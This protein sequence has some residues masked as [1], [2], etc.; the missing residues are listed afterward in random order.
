MAS[1]GGPFLIFKEFIP[2]TSIVSATFFECVHD[3]FHQKATALYLLTLTASSINIFKVDES[4]SNAKLFLCA[5]FRLYG[6]PQDVR[7]IN[8]LS[9]DMTLAESQQIVV[10]LD[11][12]KLVILSF[13]PYK[14]CLNEHRL[15]N[16]E[17]SAFGFGSEVVA[18]SHGQLVSHAQGME[19]YLSVDDMGS[20][21]C[22]LIY[23]SQFLFVPLGSGEATNGWAD[24]TQFV[25]DLHHRLGLL[26]KVL[27]FCFIAGYSQP[28]IAVLQ[29]AA[30]LPIGHAAHVLHTCTVTALAV[31]VASKSAS[32]LWQRSNL[33]HDSIRLLKLSHPAL[34]GCVAVIAV[35]ALLVVGQDVATGIAT[36]G[37]ASTTVHSSIKLSP[38]PHHKGLE[39]D[40]SRWIETRPQDH[41]QALVG[42]AKDGKMVAVHLT[43]IST[44]ECSGTAQLSSLQIEFEADLLAMSVRPSSFC[45][46]SCGRFWFIGS[47]VADGLLL[48][49]TETQTPVT[50]NPKAH[51][52]NLVGFNALKGDAG[53]SGDMASASP[54]PVAST[55]A[56][57]GA[58]SAKRPRRAP[59]IPVD[60]S[61]DMVDEEVAL[62]S[63]PMFKRW[64]VT[65]NAGSI[66]CTFY[67]YKFELEVADTVFVVGPVLSGSFTSADDSLEH[68]RALDW[69]DVAPAKE[70]NV[71]S[72]SAF[73]EPRKSKEAL[74]LCTSL[75]QH[76]AISR[77]SNGLRMA[78][79]T[80]S[81]MLAA[82]SL[83]AIQSPSRAFTLLFVGFTLKS[84]LFLCA[85]AKSIHSVGR[86]LAAAAVV[87]VSMREI[88]PADAGF[89]QSDCTLAGGVLSAGGGVV[90]QVCTQTIRVT[91][92]SDPHVLDS[93]ALQ[94]LLV[95]DS[96]DVGG[97]GGVDGEIIVSAS[98]M[99]GLVA[100][101]TSHR[102]L[103]VLQYDEEEECLLCVHSRYNNRCGDEIGSPLAGGTS[104]SM[105][106]SLQLDIV[107]GSAADSSTPSL[108]A[109][110]TDAPVS[111]SLYRGYF[112][113]NIPL[114]GSAVHG[115]VGDIGDHDEA[116]IDHDGMV[117]GT[118]SSAQGQ[119]VFGTG[120]LGALSPRSGKPTPMRSP[121][122][123]TVTTPNSDGA[124][125]PST[126][127]PRSGAAASTPA[128]PQGTGS[129]ASQTA[130]A[131]LQATENYFLYG[132]QS[133]EESSVDELGPADVSQGVTTFSQSIFSTPARGDSRMQAKKKRSVSFD[134]EMDENEANGGEGG[135]GG[136]R[137][138]SVGNV[139]DEQRA[140]DFYLV[141]GDVS[142][143][144]T[145]LRMRD[146]KCVLRTAQVAQL[147]DTIP[148]GDHAGEDLRRK[149]GMSFGEASAFSP[150]EACGERGLVDVHLHRL[151]ATTLVNGKSGDSDSISNSRLCLVALFDCGDVGVYFATEHMGAGRCFTKLEHGVVTRRPRNGPR[152]R[153]GFGPGSAGIV[154][155]SSMD[156]SGSGSPRAGMAMEGHLSSGFGGGHVATPRTDDT[157]LV[158]AAFRMSCVSNLNGSTG[159]LVPGMRPCLLTQ[160]KSNFPCLIPFGFPELPFS[161][162]G[163]YSLSPLE[164]GDVSGVATLWQEQEESAEQRR[165]LGMYQEVDGLIVMPS[166]LGTVKKSLTEQTVHFC[167]EL[168]CVTDDKTEKALLQKKTFVVACSEEEESEFEPNVLNEAE[169]EKELA[170][171]DRFVN[172]LT[173]FCQPDPKVGAAP[174]Q[175]TRRYKLSLVQGG[176]V[177]DVFKL[178]ENEQI[179][180]LEVLYMTTEKRVEPL[181]TLHPAMKTPSV[182]S[183]KRVFVAASTLVQDKHGEDTQG[184]GR[185][186]VFALDYKQLGG[187]VEATGG[188]TAV[189]AES[190]EGEAA[191]APA[192]G[193]AK[194]ATHV[195]Q[196]V[197]QTLFLESI[198][199]KLK[200]HWEG[201]GPACIVKQFGNNYILSTI[202][203]CVYVYKMNPETQE[204]EQAGFYFAQ[205]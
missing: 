184:E 101:L 189:G 64:V 113:R 104:P 92:L 90:V 56:V 74:L 200:L 39:L 98:V 147:A 120:S 132:A 26:G 81:E 190:A 172:D 148:L 149:R 19:P 139:D 20:L 123:L 154:R 58:S 108:S 3:N 68:T 102:N 17:E 35:N 30:P 86:G 155:E 130:L 144:V 5:Q 94:D 27:D 146:M 45:G 85:E 83:L 103:H 46:S 194:A 84:R 205:V 161:N 153:R 115:A 169:I 70:K 10:T 15:I 4:K 21:A 11:L 22:S 53:T 14:C 160:D 37:F 127:S 195:P 164:I 13:D 43:V 32:V 66:G 77:V 9:K 59:R 167:S 133:P 158:S 176:A 79:L 36:N 192:G 111:V 62:Y 168:L 73:V 178:N 75:D 186:L 51:M 197:A 188:A 116:A 173:S 72:A 117:V 145:V 100:V 152:Q 52:A 47:R 54:W 80:T 138:P 107:E 105:R 202:G 143:V 129:D 183:I 203:S 12:G 122:G 76:S 151:Q 137:T 159:I 49:V 162:A 199:P 93:D 121:R 187:S 29:E 16:A 88:A 156:S 177:V 134:N 131:E 95:G 38:W 55:L 124:G 180:G 97:L 23:S 142:G 7:V 87:G 163:A 6:K 141:V 106:T 65:P 1:S 119:E 170:S 109:A 67:K 57:G 126:P 34:G 125:A 171:Y 28:T 69:S 185:L 157:L 201:P 174:K 91:R 140:D 41:V 25:I 2:S 63:G 48:S 82:N 150:R 112:P 24:L 40:A 50:V 175:K 61:A 166:A 193:D 96:L 8:T 78:K 31:N 99:E 114:Q 198:L 110:I 44:D 196:S 60:G 179:L 181:V 204:L 42:V 135:G 33:P 182:I 165:V 128:A 191:Q 136:P 71:I 18:N 118:P 89:I